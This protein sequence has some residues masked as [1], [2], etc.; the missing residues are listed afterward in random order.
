MCSDAVLQCFEMDGQMRKV[1]VALR[2]VM[3]VNG[4]V[5]LVVFMLR[6][7]VY[8]DM[9][10]HVVL[11]SRSPPRDACVFECMCASNDEFNYHIDL[12]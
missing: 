3:L 11:C 7:F 1:S 2:C 9:Y 5:V 12:I 6:M 10:V 8:R 4:Y